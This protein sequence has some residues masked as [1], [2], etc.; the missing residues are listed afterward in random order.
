MYN[1][2]GDGGSNGDIGDISNWYW[3]S[4]ELMLYHNDYFDPSFPNNDA[5]YVFKWYT[6]EYLQGKLRKGSK[7][8]VLFDFHF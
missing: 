5:Y 3:S 4:S 6:V 7:S 2:I 8:I 1:T